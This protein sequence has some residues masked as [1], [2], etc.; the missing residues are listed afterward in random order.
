MLLA[1]LLVV[2]SG[3]IAAADPPAR[4]PDF[5]GA[6][7][8]RGVPHGLSASDGT[9]PIAPL[10]VVA[11]ANGSAA[12]LPSA[13]A[14]IDTCAKWLHAHPRFKIVLE[15]HTDHL[16]TAEYNEDL[17]TRRAEIVRHHLMA[18]GIPS[19]RI[20][21]VIYGEADA[22]DDVNINDRRVVMYASDRPTKEIVTASLDHMH[23]RAAVWTQRGTLF[24]EQ[25]TG[26]T[27]R[28]VVATRH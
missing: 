27:P 22:T 25:V 6:L 11:F 15:G 3:V 17:A 18:W 5:L 16:G 19:D 28:Q 13:I 2:A 7:P 4:G 24:Q 21:L 14:Q 8:P 9:A 12:L 23:A 1:S 20:L 10:D 26:K